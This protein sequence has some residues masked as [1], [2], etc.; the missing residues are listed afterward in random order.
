VTSQRASLAGDTL[1]QAA[2]AE[3]GVGVV[4]NKLE[5]VLVEDGASVSLGNSQTN[6]V[7]DTL[8]KRTSSDFDSGGVVSLGVAGSAAVN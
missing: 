4:V 2:I 6:S 7:G 8:A 1:H 3:E 5:T